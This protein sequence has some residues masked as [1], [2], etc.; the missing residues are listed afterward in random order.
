MTNSYDFVLNKIYILKKALQL[1]TCAA[2]CCCSTTTSLLTSCCGNEKSSHQL[3]GPTSGRKRSVTLVFISICLQLLFQFALAPYILDNLP[4][5]NPIRKAW[6]DG[7]EPPSSVPEMDDTQ[8]RSCVSIAGNFR[9]SAVTTL[10]F[11]IATMA[12]LCQPTANREAWPIKIIL[13]LGLVAATIVV[14]NEPYFTPVYFAIAIGKLVLYI[15][16]YALLL[17]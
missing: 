1:G 4:S 12:T 8:L 11:M 15:Y 5:S 17:R 14:P 16:I 6:L 2:W 9:V 13:Y 7:C 3:P 10:F